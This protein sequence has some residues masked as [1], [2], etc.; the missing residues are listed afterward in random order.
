MKTFR[1]ILDIL[2]AQQKRSAVLLFFVTIFVAFLDL[3]GVASIMP[4][5]AVLTNPE[6]IE[7]NRIL[8][9]AYHG[10]GFEDPNRFLFFIAGC[11]FIL[12]VTS[13]TFKAFSIYAWNRFVFM[14]E[15]TTTKRVV[16]L[17]LHQPYE[18]FLNRHSADLGK[19]ILSE[20]G[21]VI[22]GC[23]RPAIDLITY[24][25]ISVFIL[26]LLV[27]V[28]IQMALTV[29][30]IL[31]FS[32]LVV[33][34]VTKSFLIRIGKERFEANSQR[35]RSVTEA[36]G[37]VKEVKFGGLEHRFI[38]WFSDS[39]KV[40]SLHAA[41][42]YS[43]TQM[44]RLVLEAIAFGGIILIML[45]LMSGGQDVSATLPIIALYAYAGY[46]LMPALQ[47]VFSS[48]SQLHLRAPAMMALHADIMQLKS[49][50]VEIGNATKMHLN[51]S[52]VLCGIE[53]QYPKAQHPALKDVHVEIP[54]CTTIGLVGSTG[55]GK[56]TLVDVVLGLLKP[57]KGQIRVDGEILTLL[58]L[59]E[60]QN[61]IGYVPQYIF[62]S[63]D[64]V[65]ANIAFGIEKNAIDQDAVER[66]AKTANLHDFV[67]EG[68]PEGYQTEIGERGV[69][70]SGG[71]RQRIGIARA[72]Y[73][74]PQV[75]ILDE[76][77]SALDN[78]TEK[79]VMQAVEKLG[80]HITIILIAHR[81]ST[82][83]QCDR[84]YLLE[85]GKIISEGTYEELIVTNKTFSA[86]ADSV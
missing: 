71:Q 33:F 75:L 6:I 35:Y 10:L 58:N 56:T 34:K 42:G 65:A 3:L 20:A 38:Q 70:L 19:S 73:H 55:S 31:G 1:I 66:A 23:I 80:H 11:T 52:L 59:R 29:G 22:H 17:Y 15:Y 81:L 60:W 39:A 36:F 46:R 7:T 72:L 78:L 43:L 86:M 18:W 41:P 5:I 32:Y 53:F 63:D 27:V 74:E 13:L 51:R 83:R 82:V 44:P 49:S 45:F 84:I 25:I 61:S 57:Q 76:A 68:L 40:Y 24:G 54:A 77:T 8:A 37:A 21:A 79:T 67:T 50:K 28:N 16:E 9:H 47:H 69:R 64:T 12:L 2:S 14:C 62:L 26:L 4:L 30:A 48:A 85:K